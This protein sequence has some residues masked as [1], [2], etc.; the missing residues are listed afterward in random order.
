MPFS[1]VIIRG[2]SEVTRDACIMVIRQKNTKHRFIRVKRVSS[3]GT[4]VLCKNGDFWRV[5]AELLR[6][7]KKKNHTHLF[8]SFYVYSPTITKLMLTEGKSSE[9]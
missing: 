5:C 2:T 6:S 1:V 3:R 7:F 4:D 9:R 8:G